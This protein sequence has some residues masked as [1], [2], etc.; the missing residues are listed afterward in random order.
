MI[1]DLLHNQIVNDTIT[2][3]FKRSVNENLVPA[4][5]SIYGEDMLGIQMYE[6][7]LADEFLLDGVFY[8]PMTV[9]KADEQVT[10]WVAWNVTEGKFTDLIPYSYVG[11][12]NIEFDLSPGVPIDFETAI[13]GRSRY[14]EDGLIKICVRS[15]SPSPTFLAGKYSQTFIDEMARQLTVAIESATG[16]SGIADS[17]VELVMIFA[18]NTYLEHTHLRWPTGKASFL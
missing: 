11:E 1:I 14:C 9:I 13:I 17:S 8:Y 16:I 6:D 4:L 2:E 15:T 7:H 10:H 3:G 12:E 18:P 5:V